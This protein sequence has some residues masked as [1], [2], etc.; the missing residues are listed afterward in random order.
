MSR[1]VIAWIAFL[2]VTIITPTVYKTAYAMP[3][4][5]AVLVSLAVIATVLGVVT[6]RVSGVHVWSIVA[7]LIGLVIGQWWLIKSILVL[8]SMMRPGFGT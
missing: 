2:L 3:G 1:L 7:V 8:A 6:L 4:Y 5:F